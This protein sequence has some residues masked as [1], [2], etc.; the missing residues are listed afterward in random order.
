MQAKESLHFSTSAIFQV[1]LGLISTIETAAAINI[2][3]PDS[4]F[5]T[6]LN[7]HLIKLHVQVFKMY[8]IFPVFFAVP[9]M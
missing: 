3:M 7:C 8:L 4:T 5:L 9:D 1:L 6:H 2:V